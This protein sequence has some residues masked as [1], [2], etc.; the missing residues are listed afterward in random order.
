LDSEQIARLTG[1][2]IGTYVNSY[3]LNNQDSGYATITS[4]TAILETFDGLFDMNLWINQGD[5]PSLKW[6]PLIR[7]T[8][9]TVEERTISFGLT[10]TGAGSSGQFTA[11]ELFAGTE[12][13]A[14]LE[15]NQ[16]NLYTFSNLLYNTTYVIKT[17]FAVVY[18]A[19]DIIEVTNQF[20]AKTNAL[21]GTPEVAFT[22][23]Y[24]GSDKVEFDFDVIDPQS[25]GQVTAIALLDQDYE[26]LQNLEDLSIREF[27]NLTT[28][29]NYRLAVTYAYDLR[30]DL[31]EKTFVV[32]AA[33]V[34][35]PYVDLI[36]VD[37]LNLQAG[38]AI[39]ANDMIVVQININNIDKVNFTRV[40]INDVWYTV[41]N[42]TDNRITISIS[43][44]TLNTLG[45]YLLNVQQIE[46]THNALVYNYYM[47][48]RNTVELMINGEISAQQLAILDENLQPLEH[49]VYGEKYVVQITFDNPTGYLI[50]S[51]QLNQYFNGEINADWL[52]Q[53][54]TVLTIPLTFNQNFSMWDNQ[55]TIQLVGFNYSNEAVGL[56]NKLTTIY[57]SIIVLRSK[58]IQPVSTPQ[59][60]NLME[61][62]YHYQLVNDINL[63]GINWNPKHFSGI[64]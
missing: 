49:I 3:S 27:T 2:Q 47:T 42:F 22:K 16:T 41:N 59:E 10:A 62:G 6:T 33:F 7:L 21:E 15:P 61:A 36:S 11:I 24:P 56:K 4:K 43:A 29:T 19:D 46:A 37:V 53:G 45:A 55:K 34:T 28:N 44:A 63:S 39:M 54:N 17:K 18:A 32:Y 31:G 58:A 40:K 26:V 1:D 5:Y 64:F 8:N 60:L 30:D 38:E 48:S 57:N 35:N 50:N 9:L 52:S 13:I 12:K 23:V 20:E 51:V 14:S 25:Y